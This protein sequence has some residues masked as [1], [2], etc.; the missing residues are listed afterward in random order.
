MVETRN[1]Y[2]QNTPMLLKVRRGLR[3][4]I[5]VISLVIFAGVVSKSGPPES[6]LCNMVG[7]WCSPS[8]PVIGALYLTS[9]NPIT[10]YLLLDVSEDQIYYGRCTVANGS[11]RVSMQGPGREPKQNPTCSASTHIRID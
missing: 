8:V 5:S 11:G 3:R 7:V 1:K 6:G 4:V 2:V 9:A 10:I